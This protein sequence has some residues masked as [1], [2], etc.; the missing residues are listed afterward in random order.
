MNISRGTRQGCLCSPILFPL[1]INPL[2]VKLLQSRNI[3]PIVTGGY[4]TKV[5][6]YADDVAVLT[7]NP[8]EA[9]IEIDKIAESHGLLSG[10]ALNKGKT[11]VLCTDNIDYNDQGKQTRLSTWGSV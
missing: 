6:A 4:E 8:A 9:I 10:Y 1:Y 5:L 2:V 3:K 7:P 11:I